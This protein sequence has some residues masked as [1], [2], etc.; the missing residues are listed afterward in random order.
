ML[1][2]RRRLLL[3]DDSKEDRFLMKRA[4][5]ECGLDYDVQEAW[6][7]EEAALLLTRCMQNDSLPEF[8]ILDIVL[9]KLSGM[10]L[11]EKLA[12]HGFAQRT[13]VIVLSSVLP[14]KET[15]KLQQLGVLG[16]FEKPLELEDFLSLGRKVKDLSLAAS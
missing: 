9:P 8:V 16:V 1:G 15:A 13:R 11:L 6:D 2:T 4:L 14:T 5:T 7:G 3:V 10:E 12:S